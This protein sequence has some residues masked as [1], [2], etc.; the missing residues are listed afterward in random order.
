MSFVRGGEVLVNVDPAQRPSNARA[1]DTYRVSKTSGYHTTQSSDSEQT[2]SFI[3]P[4]AAPEQL[5]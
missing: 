2:N 4:L 3:N 1:R 5:T